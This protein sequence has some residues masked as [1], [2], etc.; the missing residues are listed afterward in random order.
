MDPQPWTLVTSDSGPRKKALHFTLQSTHALHRLGLWNRIVRRSDTLLKLPK[1]TQQRL[2]QNGRVW[3]HLL[4]CC[5][6][7]STDT[8]RFMQLQH[9]IFELLSPQPAHS[10]KRHVEAV[11]KRID[12]AFTV[13]STDSASQLMGSTVQLHGCSHVF[14]VDECWGW[15]LFW[16]LNSAVFKGVERCM[17]QCDITTNQ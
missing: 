14:R 4:I 1:Q 2:S 10:T 16:T 6:L 11:W 3:D 9:R 17:K 13:H 15:E 8:A 7:N 5:R 12:C